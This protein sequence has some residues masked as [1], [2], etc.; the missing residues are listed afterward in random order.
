MS[1]PCMSSSVTDHPL[2]GDR[3]HDPPHVVG[4]GRVDPVL[5]PSAASVAETGHAH[6]GPSAAHP[7]QQ[8]PTRVAGTSVRPAVPVARANHVFR[9]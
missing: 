2:A 3:G 7:A 4:H 5:G 6:H 8:R 9:Y 1:V